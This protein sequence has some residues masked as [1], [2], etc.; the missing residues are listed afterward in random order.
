MFNFCKEIETIFNI[1]A[2]YA[3]NSGVNVYFVGGMVRDAL[4][5][6]DMG[7]IDIL[8]EGSAIVFAHGL[9]DFIDNTFAPINVPHTENPCG[10]RLSMEVK[11][12]HESFNTI[13]VQING[14]EID[15]A[16]TR[17]EEYPK[18]GCLPVVK[19]IG[20]PIETDLK[21]RDFTV[22]AMAYNTHTGLVDPF[23]G[24]KDLRRHQICCVGNPVDR[25]HEDALR[26]MRA[27]RFSSVYGFA[28]EE[29][30]A[31]AIH[32]LAPYLKNI[33]VERIQVELNKLL[34]G[35]GVLE[36]L[37]DYSDVM[38]V[39]IPEIAPC[40]GFQQNNP[41]HEYTVCDHIAHA[42][43]ND[44][45]DDLSVKIA[46][47]LHDIGKPQCYSEDE[48][49]GHFHGHS[50]P[51]HDIADRVMQ[52]LRFDNKTREDVLT[53]VLYHD[54]EIAPT[55]KAVRR[56]LSKIGESNFRKLLAVKLA[57]IKAHA[58]STQQ[59]RIDKCLALYGILDE[60]IAQGQC[61]SIKDLAIG[62][63]DIRSLGVPEGKLIGDILNHILDKVISGDLPNEVRPQMLDVQQYLSEN[64]FKF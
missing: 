57:D 10:E 7:D 19:N 29:D 8:V 25:F 61:F 23:H 42:V 17:E 20:C 63:K 37:L 40:I 49:G 30:T 50:V 35:K 45:G 39:I 38:A 15:L 56:W 36:I 44:T 64:H 6:R 62:G 55:H 48:W 1:I 27:L 5:K 11:S 60:V 54:S 32:Q 16:S 12:T 33:A 3:L 22:N 24:E 34:L 58:E 9:K 21:R 26:I 4:M 46:L 51:S 18:S 14:I 31:K 41:Y 28:I 13:K 43:A 53:L 52:R 59:P 2:E 47:L